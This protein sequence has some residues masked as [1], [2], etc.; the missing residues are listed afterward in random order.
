MMAGVEDG[1]PPA[2]LALLVEDDAR[3]AELT[4]DYLARHAVRVTV[5]GLRF[6]EQLLAPARRQA[7]QAG[8]R[9]RPLWA[10]GDEGLDI[11]VEAIGDA[12]TE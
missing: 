4:R 2:I 7:R 5:A 12:R 9:I 6:G 10:T 8:V 11:A 1:S 3:L